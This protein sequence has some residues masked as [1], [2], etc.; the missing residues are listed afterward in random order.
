SFA[1]FS[2]LVA[3]IIIVG[4][5]VLKIHV[6]KSE[7]SGR[8]IASSKPSSGKSH[9][10]TEQSNPQPKSRARPSRTR[11]KPSRRSQQDKL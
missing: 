4:H 3:L 1:V 11:S 8:P 5:F 10:L 9:Q 2:L 7:R 6:P